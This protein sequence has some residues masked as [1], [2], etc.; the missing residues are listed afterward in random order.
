MPSS[1]GSTPE[2][3]I[4]ACKFQT[5][6]FYVTIWYGVLEYHESGTEGSEHLRMDRVRW[7]CIVRLMTVLLGLKVDVLE[8]VGL[9]LLS[10]MVGP[11]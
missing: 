2:L 8:M 6:P 11:S 5:P 1:G 10:R 7:K 9:M 3:N 4:A